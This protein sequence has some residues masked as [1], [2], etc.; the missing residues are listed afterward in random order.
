MSAFPPHFLPISAT[1][2][3]LMAHRAEWSP[4]AVPRGPSRPLFVALPQLTPEGCKQALGAGGGRSAARI[5][6]ISLSL[7]SH[8][9]FAREIFL[10]GVCDS[11]MA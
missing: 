5:H 1:N 7:I 3:H 2:L 11:V 9:S 10:T 8:A 6:L 4:I